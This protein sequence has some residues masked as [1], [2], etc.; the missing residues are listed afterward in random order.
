MRILSKILN[1]IS[2]RVFVVGL[3]ILIQICWGISML[4]RLTEYSSALNMVLTVLSLFAVLYIINKDDNPAYKLAWI[5]PILVFPLFGGFLYLLFGDK[6][7]TKRMRIQM[8]KAAARISAFSVSDDNLLDIVQAEDKTAYGQ[9]KYIND[10]A[11]YPAYRNTE[12][13]YY[14]SGEECYPILLEELRKAKHFIFMEYFIVEEA[15]MWDGILTIL[16][17]KAAEGVEVRFMYDDMGCVALLPYKYYK[18]LEEYGIKSVAFN[19]VIPFFSLVMNHRDH[20]KMTIIDGNVGFMGGW[21][22]A[23]EYIN[24]KNRFGYWKDTAV[25]LKG[26]AVWNLTSMFLVTWNS[27]RPDKEE[28]IRR[29]M[30]EM[31][32]ENSTDTEGYVQPYGD[33]PLDR[34]NVSES[35]FLNMINSAQD[36]IYMSTPYLVIDNEMMTALILAAKRGVDV[37][38]VTPGI[39]DKKY[40]FILTQSYYSQLV[41]GG[42][43]IYQYDPG[44][45]HAKSFVCDDKFAIVGT[46]NLDYRS[47]Y[48]HFECGTFFYRTPVVAAVKEDLLEMTEVSTQQTYAMTQKHIFKRLAQAVLRVL[49]P[50]M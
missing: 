19:P 16:K 48:L 11:H 22:L 26:D 45:V 12:S 47:L 20:R 27:I 50:L 1:F 18:K 37:R 46:I 14:K 7:P 29:Y 13:Y 31:I 32:M 28:D 5:I 43:K 41:K 3:I 4:T 33:S 44:F 38:I 42:V 24:V 39:P 23:D 49:A 15:N 21:N 30:P 2:K 40:V 36:Y 34:E 8:D 25:M 9:M 6:R 10:C 35:V 17:Q